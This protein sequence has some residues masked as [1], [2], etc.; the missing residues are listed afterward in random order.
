[1]STAIYQVEV[2]QQ[3][4][5][6]LFYW[7]MKLIR[8]VKFFYWILLMKILVA[9]RGLYEVWFDNFCSCGIYSVDIMVSRDPPRKASRQNLF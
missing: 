7:E 2:S 1:M 6:S 5:I 4:N 9:W 8:E 3:K